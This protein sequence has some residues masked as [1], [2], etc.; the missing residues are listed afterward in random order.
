MRIGVFSKSDSS[1]GGASKVAEDM[2]AIFSQH[3]H[4]VKHYVS[5]SKKG[6]TEIRKLACGRFQSIAA[7]VAHYLKKAGI[8]DVIPIELPFVLR[9]VEKEKF[10]VLH[11]HD[12]TSAFS[13]FTL[14]YL[15]R[16][17][18]V[19]WTLHDCSA[20]TAGCLFPLQCEKFRS[21]CSSCP[22][23][24]IWPLDL[25][26][27]NTMLLLK[28]KKISHWIGNLHLVS[29]SLW[30]SNLA[31]SSGLIRKRPQIISNPI[32]TDHFKKIDKVLARNLLGLDLRRLYI[33][34]SAG[35]IFD[36][37]KGIEYALQCVKRVKE[38]SPFLIIVGNINQYFIDALRGLD[39][40]A[41]GYVAD[42]KLLNILYAAAD[43][44]L[45]TS[46]ADNSPITILE[47][48]ASGTPIVGFMTGG[49]GEIVDNN[50]NGMIVAPK[51]T[52]ALTAALREVIRS[53]IYV[54]WSDRARN[55][56]INQYSEELFYNQHYLL[57]QKL[58]ARSYERTN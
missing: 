30:M 43:I 41:M 58:L 26:Y 49:T 32:N 33:L 51:D 53:K 36:E 42:N 1:G 45:F 23:F 2:S 29:P 9:N 28:L 20:F 39:F 4:Y 38:H 24:G 14:S 44:F 40:R 25:Y 19:I 57:Y 8:P 31:F 15:S 34:L 10:D 54:K 5:Y 16:I 12:I 7:K 22:Q 48:M 13:S 37:R 50:E 21:N 3:G 6:I 17:M 52:D 55:K 11:F 35:S 27:R 47:S 56:I 18:P 46:I